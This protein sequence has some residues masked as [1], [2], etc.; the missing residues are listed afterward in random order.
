MMGFGRRIGVGRE[1]RPGET[2]DVGRPGEM[3]EGVGWRGGMCRR[4]V[5]K[6]DGL[7]SWA[8]GAEL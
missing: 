4:E 3:R 1:G 7:L 5:I 6:A 8:S 2:G